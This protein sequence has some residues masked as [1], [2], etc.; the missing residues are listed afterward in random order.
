ML[1]LSEILTRAYIYTKN[2]KSLWFFGFF[3][4]GW[5]VMNFVRR[6]DLNA[7]HLDR[8]YRHILNYVTNHPLELVISIISLILL[9]VI[10]SFV[11]AIARS[12]IIHAADLLDKEEPVT[13]RAVLKY[14]TKSVWRVF[15]AGLFTN[16]V[17]IFFFAWLA[18]PLWLVFKNGF[19][20]RGFILIVA[21][22]VIFIPIIIVLSL[23]NIF[24][25]CY[26]VIYKLKLK[27]AFASAFDL[28]AVFWQQVIALFVMLFVIYFFF[29]FFSATL[30]GF[31]GVLAYLPII[32]VKSLSLQWFA[33]IILALIVIL[34]LALLLVN[35]ILNVFTNFAWTIFF[36]DI[37]KAKYIKDAKPVGQHAGG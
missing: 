2:H 3:L 12:S 14:A 30:V 20:L 10:A 9:I 28:L 23:V 19:E 16:A 1:S 18:L 34:S 24:A 29:F 11:G 4:T 31:I 37:V 27:D 13:F 22:L 26:I 15:F 21:A 32:L 8:Y 7:D 6:V 35:A 5:G 33:A 17:I 36:L 25:C